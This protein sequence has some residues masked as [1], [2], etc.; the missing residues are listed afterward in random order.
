MN[1]RNLKEFER[2]NVSKKSKKE[3]IKVSSSDFLGLDFSEKKRYRGVPP[4]LAPVVEPLLEGDFPEVEIIV[5]DP[6]KFENATPSTAM[7]STEADDSTGLYKSEVSTG[8][9]STTLKSNEGD[10]SMGL[11]KPKV[12]TWGVFPRPSNISKTVY[13]I[14]ALFLTI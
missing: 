11:Y 8:G 12:S 3:E 5:G 1:S 7:G 10:D 9:A 4:G 6:S 14:Y 13:A 2:N